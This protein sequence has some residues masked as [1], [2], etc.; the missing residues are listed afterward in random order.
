MGT[1]AEILTI[2]LHK[3]RQDS[4]NEQLEDLRVAARRLGMYDAEDFLRKHL[5]GGDT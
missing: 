5:E 4:L 3:Q 1:P 2:P